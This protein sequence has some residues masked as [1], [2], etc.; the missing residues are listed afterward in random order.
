LEPVA[1]V[2]VHGQ[3]KEVMDQIPF[4]VQLLLPAVEVVVAMVLA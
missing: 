2:V 4:L 1:L 3:H